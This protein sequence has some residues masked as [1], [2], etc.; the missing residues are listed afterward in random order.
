MDTNL[1]NGGKY[2]FNNKNNIKSRLYKQ[3]NVT[4]NDYKKSLVD[5][6]VEINYQKNMYQSL[7]PSTT[8]NRIKDLENQLKRVL[9][10][11]KSPR[12]LSKSFVGKG[13]QPVSYTIQ[14]FR[15]ETNQFGK[16]VGSP[17]NI[18]KQVSVKRTSPNKQLK[19]SPTKQFKPSPPSPKSLM[20]GT[21]RMIASRQLRHRPSRILRSLEDSRRLSRDVIQAS[22][23]RRQKPR[24]LS[25]IL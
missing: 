9:A 2:F 3:Y 20:L 16:G 1:I 10:N 19:P 13:S 7:V 14:D 23:A 6:L 4:K 15:T 11:Y 5:D 12:S 8:R 24:Y 22:L 25:K 21:P 17:V 18:Q